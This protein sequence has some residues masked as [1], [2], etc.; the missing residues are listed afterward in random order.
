[1]CFFIVGQGKCCNENL[2]NYK[3]MNYFL[4][5]TSIYYINKDL[6]FKSF[7]SQLPKEVITYT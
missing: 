1:M 4:S 7:V 3:K 2:R 5:G 6:V